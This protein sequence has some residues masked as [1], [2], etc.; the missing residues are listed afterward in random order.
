MINGLV[1]HNTYLRSH[2]K[3]SWNPMRVSLEKDIWPDSPVLS[4]EQ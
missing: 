4:P 2:S 3:K 1:L